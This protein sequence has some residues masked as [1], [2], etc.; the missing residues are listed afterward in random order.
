MQFRVASARQGRGGGA[1]TAEEFRAARR[2]L[3]LS[4]RG[5]AVRLGLAAASERNVR[6]YEREGPP[7]RIA[8]AVR[9]VLRQSLPEARP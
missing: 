4:C 7:P 6:R 8:E 1:V 9:E 5:M 3:G 2:A